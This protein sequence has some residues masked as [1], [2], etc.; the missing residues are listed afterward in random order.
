MNFYN[1]D[2][3]KKPTINKNNWCLCP[4]AKDF[5]VHFDSSQSI[6]IIQKSFTLIEN[7]EDGS[8]QNSTANIADYFTSNINGLSAFQP[9][10]KVLLYNNLNLNVSND[11]TTTFLVINIPSSSSTYGGPNIFTS[12]YSSMPFDFTSVNELL[13]YFTDNSSYLLFDVLNNGIP[14]QPI[15]LPNNIPIIFTIEKS[16]IYNV[17]YQYIYKVNGKQLPTQPPVSSPS[18]VANYF[19]I[20]NFIKNLASEFPMEFTAPIYIGE[21]MAF[22]RNLSYE[23]IE[24]IESYLSEKWRISIY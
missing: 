12:L 18:S 16:Y 8:I 24:R 3:K 22:Q 19:M 5:F 20:G 23:E 17:G 2:N 7:T 13:G 15:E 11:N 21:I 10:D 14:N 4:L 1:P 9:Q 6:S